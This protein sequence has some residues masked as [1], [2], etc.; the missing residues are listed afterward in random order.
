[1]STLDQIKTDIM[2]RLS[3]LQ[4]AVAEHT[5]LLAVKKQ[6][7]ELLGTNASAPRNRK[8]ANGR[9]RRRRTVTSAA[10]AAASTAAPTPAPVRRATRRTASK[11]APRGQNRAKVLAALTAAPAPL[12]VADLAAATGIRDAVVYQVLTRLAESGAVEKRDA[13]GGR[14][15]YIATSTTADGASSSEAPPS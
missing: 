14:V 10:R 9:R 7:D 3:E 15:A 2:Q 4:E 11:R 6:W 5:Q 13:G 1:V 12:F 8:P